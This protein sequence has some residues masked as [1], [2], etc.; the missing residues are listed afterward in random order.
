MHPYTITYSNE[1]A[2]NNAV[3]HANILS[4][5][6]LR[7][8]ESEHLGSAR[9]ESQFGHWLSCL[10]VL[11]FFS[12]LKRKIP[13]NFLYSNQ[14][15]PVL[16]ALCPGCFHHLSMPL[17]SMLL[18]SS[19][20]SDTLPWAIQCS[21]QTALN[22]MMIANNYPECYP[23]TWEIQSENTKNNQCN[24]Y[25]LIKLGKPLERI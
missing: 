7:Q 15:G 19:A 14:C 5:V 25:L 12:V 17:P 2:V 16:S 6:A 21:L 10:R 8:C 3:L 13:N 4:P 24:T 9:F 23:F 22:D 18:A 1:S 11:S 20:T